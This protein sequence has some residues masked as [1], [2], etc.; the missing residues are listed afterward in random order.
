MRARWCCKGGLAGVLATVLAFPGV[1]RAFER[2]QHAGLSAGAMGFSPNGG[3][4]TFGPNLGLHYSY[5]VSDAFTIAVEADAS[6]FALGTAPKN[7][8]PQ[9]TFVATGGV[10]LFYVFDVLRWVPYAGGLAGA[11]YFGG[12]YLSKGVVAF[13][14]QLAAGLD[15]QLTRSWTVGAAYRQHFF[16]T[17]TSTFGEAVSLRFEYVWGW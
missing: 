15:Y 16:V 7:P 4:T 10:G 9:P 11:G 17:E 6:G 14:V 8:P 13:D 5:G 3:G 1:A 12:G 2:Q